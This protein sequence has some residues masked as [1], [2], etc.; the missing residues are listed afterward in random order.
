MAD[1]NA[2]VDQYIQLRDKKDAMKREYDARVEQVDKLLE[3][4]EN[5]LLDQMQETGVESMRTEAGTAYISVR[6]SSSVKD[7]EAFKGF[8]FSSG[9]WE[10]ADIRAS[11]T[12][13]A[14]YLKENNELPPGVSWSSMKTVNI[15]R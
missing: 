12:A 14:D 3:K 10:L 11:K 7:K 5:Y 1:V 4:I 9:K 13:V 8:L 15:R 6:N 2:L